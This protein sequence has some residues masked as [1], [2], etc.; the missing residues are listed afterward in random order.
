MA[1]Q[2]HKLGP[3]LLGDDFDEEAA[4]PVEEDTSSGHV[5]TDEEPVAEEDAEDED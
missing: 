2:F 3:G 4:A 1:R 5:L